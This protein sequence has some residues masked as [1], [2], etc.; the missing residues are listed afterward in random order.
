M[1]IAVLNTQSTIEQAE[2]TDTNSYREIHI[3]LDK[4]THSLPKQC[5]TL[6]NNDSLSRS[7]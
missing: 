5:N 6:Q 3:L 4:I 1:L 2:L 7:G